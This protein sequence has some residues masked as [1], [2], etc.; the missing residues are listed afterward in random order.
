MKHYRVD[1]SYTDAGFDPTGELR[2]PDFRRL[3]ADNPSDATVKFWAWVA[4]E[5]VTM[6][7]DVRVEDVY[8]V[9]VVGRRLD[10]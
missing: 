1:Y 6:P 10:A 5:K 8:E 2:T 4:E 9:D 7:S 3:P